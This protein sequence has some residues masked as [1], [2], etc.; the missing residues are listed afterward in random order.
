MDSMTKEELDLIKPLDEG[1]MK[2]IS[3]G[4]GVHVA[5]ITFLL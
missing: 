2:R 3:R 5:E 1:R 4:S